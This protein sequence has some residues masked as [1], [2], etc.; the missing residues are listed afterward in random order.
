MR[1]AARDS[2][3]CRTGA[4]PPP[5]HQAIQSKKEVLTFNRDLTSETLRLGET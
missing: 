3:P 4:E 2:A 5:C 1:A